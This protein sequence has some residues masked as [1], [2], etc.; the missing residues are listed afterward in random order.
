MFGASTLCLLAGRHF[1]VGPT[2]RD[3]GIDG[4]LTLRVGRLVGNGLDPLYGLIS[5]WFGFAALS[6]S[7]IWAG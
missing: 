7:W 1:G 2:D 3:Q 4:G 6:S 5:V